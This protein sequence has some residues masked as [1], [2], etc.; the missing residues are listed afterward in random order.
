MTID[1]NVEEALTKAR[2]FAEQG[3]AIV[4]N[5]SLALAQGYAQKVGQDISAQV[6]D[7]ERLGY[8]NGVPVVLTKAREWA[9]KGEAT[10]M[11]SLL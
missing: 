3:E 8:E 6:R 9:E 10:V 4:M 7:I 1:K 2:G 11:N 5:S